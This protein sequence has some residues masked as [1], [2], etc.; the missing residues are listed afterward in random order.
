MLRWVSNGGLVRVGGRGVRIFFLDC[1]T[2]F[3]LSLV[4][5]LLPRDWFLRLLPQVS[6]GG[7]LQPEAAR[8]A[9]VSDLV[10]CLLQ[11]GDEILKVR[12]Y[13]F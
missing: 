9:M 2:Q 5:L 13:C 3:G 7:F 10:F 8:G 4:L 12:T 11:A 1:F 6:C